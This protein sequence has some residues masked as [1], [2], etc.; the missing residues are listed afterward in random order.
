M[1]VLQPLG[2]IICLGALPIVASAAGIKPGQYQM[3]SPGIQEICLKS[4]GI[5][6]GTT[7][8]FSG[9]WI[10]D[11]PALRDKAVIY[12]NYALNGG[13]S[14]FANDA[15]RVFKTGSGDAIDWFDWFDDMTYER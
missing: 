15:I 13:N 14:G 10:N 8:N 2:F 3:G 1:R 11:P 7:F 12:G 4:D 6:Y 9:H 5:W